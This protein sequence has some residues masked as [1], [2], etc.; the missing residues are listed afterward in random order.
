[1]ACYSILQYISAVILYSVDAL[2]GNIQVTP[3]FVISNFKLIYIDMFLV[4]P[5]AILSNAPN[6]KT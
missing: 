5:L 2:L 6:N 3:F 1:M 4:L